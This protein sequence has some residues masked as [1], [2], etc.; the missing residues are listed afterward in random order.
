MIT[1]S[2]LAF[3]ERKCCAKITHNVLSILGTL[4]CGYS[5]CNMYVVEKGQIGLTQYSDQPEILPQGRH[6]LLSPW[7]KFIGIKNENDAVIIHGTIHIIKVQAGEL[8]YGVDMQSG[9][10]I[11][12]TQGEHIIDSNTFEWVK[13]ITLREPLTA[14]GKLTVIRVDTGYVA[15]CYK[16]GN[17]VILKPGVNH[18]FYILFIYLLRVHCTLFVTYL[19]HI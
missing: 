7:N 17:L 4:L 15:Y 10:P 18:S 19:I 6:V 5:C 14:L 8:G 3:V 1:Y 13:F 12:L 2:K 9:H 16:Q 11:L